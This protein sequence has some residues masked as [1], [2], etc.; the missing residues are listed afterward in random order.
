MAYNRRSFDA[1]SLQMEQRNHSDVYYHQAGSGQTA[2]SY[3]PGGKYAGATAATTRAPPTRPFYK[4][5]WFKFGA[6]LLLIA[7]IVAATVGGVFGS[8]DNDDNA[9]E[10]AKGST[11]DGGSDGNPNTDN[12]GSLFAVSANGGPQTTNFKMMPIYPTT[13]FAARPAQ[14]TV[15]TTQSLQWD[16]DNWTAPAN[17]SLTNI[18]PDHPRLIATNNKWNSLPRLIRADPYLAEWNATII[19]N[20]SRFADLPPVVY[21]ADGGLS[22]NGVL[23]VARQIQLRIKHWGYAYRMTKDPKWGERMWAELLH[24]SG[25]GTESFG[26]PPDRWNTQHF[27]D[28]AEFSAAFG[29]A[30]DWLYDYWTPERRTAIMWSLLNLG[31][32]YGNL[33]YNGAGTYGWWRQVNGNW[34]CVCNNGLTLGALAIAG[35]DP[36][37]IAASILSHSA[38]NAAGN[39][40]DGVLADGTWSET[41]DYWFFGTTGHAQMSAALLSATGGEFGL[42]TSNKDFSKTGEYHMFVTGFYERFNTGDQGPNKFTANANSMMHYGKYFNIPK[43]TLFQRDQADAAEPIGVFYYDPSTVG[44]WWDGQD[45]DHYFDNQEDSWAAMRSSWTNPNGVYVAMKGSRLLGHQSHGNLDTGTFVID[46]LGTR[47]IGLLG[48][49]DYLSPGYFS[50]GEGQDSQRWLYYRQRTEG[51]N[52]LLM[53]GANQLV[54][55]APTS[56]Y[57]STGEKQDSLAYVA[58]TNSAAFYTVDMS[59]AYTNASGVSI[60][61]GIRLLNA[62]RQILL[63]DEIAGA[64]AAVQWRA[65]TNATVAL[66]SD[67]RTATLT[68]AGQTMQAQLLSPAGAK[69]GT[70]QPVRLSTDPALP[71]GGTDDP[72]PGVTVL[73]IDLGTTDSNVQVVFNPQWSGM[74]ANAYVTPRSVALASWSTTSHN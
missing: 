43:Y 67:G 39:C 62:R 14:P 70:A 18:R 72:N 55:A 71:S 74:D 3:G 58:P 57:G 66:S 42:L 24:A 9:S 16:A 20:A 30:Y 52:T 59:T 17:P 4:K 19:A 28:V 41:S 36:T 54:T 31:L 12:N 6:P 48:N 40:A 65:H 2:S 68:L 35:D 37:G 51:S 73:T 10:N 47:W 7:I 60:Q 69:F 25:N 21:Y 11:A 53:G 26:N 56:K 15:V 49:N 33:A 46:A 34:N 13:T 8:R 64:T 29:Y 27:L 38:S 61:R 1:G 32:N 45:L 22:G 23:D 44:Q 5:P 50:T 63:Q